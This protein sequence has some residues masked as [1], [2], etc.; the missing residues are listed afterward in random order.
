MK[1]SY[2]ASHIPS[3]KYL[4]CKLF[5][6]LSFLLFNVQY[7]IFILITHSKIYVIF[8]KYVS[9]SNDYNFLLNWCLLYRLTVWFMN[10][11]YSICLKEKLPCDVWFFNDLSSSYKLG[12]IF[13]S[14]SEIGLITGD[15]ASLFR[16]FDSRMCEYEQ[17][18]FWIIC[19]SI[20]SVSSMEN[21][22]SGLSVHYVAGAGDGLTTLEEIRSLGWSEWSGCLSEDEEH[23]TTTGCIA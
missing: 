12:D 23:R 15:D 8:P 17:I 19:E 7:I 14:W 22:L 6:L 20:K 10:E 5:T 1:V 13:I 3:I 16:G 18:T 21:Y 4:L 2:F 11:K 9:F